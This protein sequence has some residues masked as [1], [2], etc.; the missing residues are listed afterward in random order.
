[1]KLDAAQMLYVDEPVL[2]RADQPQR[3]AMIAIERLPAESIGNEHIRTQRILEQ[4]DRPISIEPFENHM[5]D[6]RP[7]RKQRLDPRPIQSLERHPLPPQPGSRP[8][9]N[10]VKVGLHHD[11]RQLREIIHRQREVLYKS[12]TDHDH[13][14]IRHG[15]WRI[16]Q[17]RAEARKPIDSALTRR[18]CHFDPPVI[19]YR[20]TYAA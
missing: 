5:A 6:H 17:M 19:R 15:R 10:T 8:P 18:K 7:R 11:A 4:H 14:L 16:L 13:R 20:I 9:R 3:C 12:S 1:M 2:P